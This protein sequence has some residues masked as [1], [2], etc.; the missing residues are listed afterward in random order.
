LPKERTHKQHLATINYL[1]AKLENDLAH[2]RYTF[3][4]KKEEMEELITACIITGDVLSAEVPLEEYIK[5]ISKARINESI[6]L[7]GTG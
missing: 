7:S 3:S 1:K 5:L 4:L 6:L 2:G